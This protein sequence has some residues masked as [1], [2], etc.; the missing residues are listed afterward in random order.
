[1]S[2]IEAERIVRT[3][4]KLGVGVIAERARKIAMGLRQYK[5]GSVWSLPGGKIDPFKPVVRCGQRELVEE[6]NLVADDLKVLAVYEFI[7]QEQ[8]YHFITFGAVSHSI[9]GDLTN[10]EPRIFAAW[11]WFDLE[12]IPAPLFPPTYH[13][14][15]AYQTA[16]NKALNIPPADPAM[17]AHRFLVSAS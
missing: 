11:D 17:I 9:S 3:P 7:E 1:V 14:L 5:G 10:L 13:L 16:I 12:S 4:P 2:Q 6:T 15:A 8:N